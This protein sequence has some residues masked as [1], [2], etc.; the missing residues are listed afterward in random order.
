MCFKIRLRN[1][2]QA[3]CV[4]SANALEVNGPEGTACWAQVGEVRSKFV[5]CQNGVKRCLGAEARGKVNGIAI[6]TVERAQISN[7]CP[8]A[9]AT[10]HADLEIE[11]MLLPNEHQIRS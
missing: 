4:D 8:H 7:D 5:G 1:P 3:V 6:H 9:R 11:V 10:V 2:T